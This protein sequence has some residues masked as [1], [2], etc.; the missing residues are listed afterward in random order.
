MTGRIMQ[1]K[2]RY[3]F[4]SNFFGS[5]IEI[6]GRRYPTVEHY[7]QSMKSLDPQE[8]EKI[9]LARSAKLAKKYGRQSVLR[10]D[11]EEIKLQV[12]ERGLRIKFSNPEL[13][14]KLIK[15]QDKY[16]MEGNTWN[17][18]YW[19]VDLESR[20]GKNHLGKLLMKI[21]KELNN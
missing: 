16:L 1:F 20:K 15:T 5:P 13:R 11:W 10:A 2:G 14:E 7:F 18:R 9:R 21:R 4:L 3:Q 12:M 6:D 17:D 19:G 8:Q